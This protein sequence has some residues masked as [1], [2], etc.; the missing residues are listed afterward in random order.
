MSFLLVDVS[1]LLQDVS[2]LSYLLSKEDLLVGI[3]MP[4]TLTGGM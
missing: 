2:A 4:E 3:E 1:L